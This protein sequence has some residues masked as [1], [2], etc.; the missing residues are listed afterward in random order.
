MS[1]LIRMGTSGNGVPVFTAPNSS[2]ELSRPFGATFDQSKS[3]WMYPAY[4]PVAGIVLE[5]MKALGPTLVFSDKVLAYR[6]TL[7]RIAEAYAAT[8]LPTGF[9]FITPPYAHQ[10]LGLA[11]VYYMLR[12]ALFYAPGLGKSKIAIDLL[13][14]LKFTGKL[15]RTLLLGPLVTIRNWGHEIDIHSGGELTWTAVLGTPEAKR[16]VIETSTADVLLVTYDTAS[17]YCDALLDKYDYRNIIADESHNIKSWSAS[18]TK[19]AAEL[20]Q[21]ADRRV[22]MT[23]TPTLGSP[24]DLYGQFRFLGT[25][26][27]PE[28]YFKYRERFFEFS[29]SNKYAILG[30]KNLPILNR[31]TL[32]ISVKKSKEECLDLPERTIQ[33]ISFDLSR[34]ESALYNK[35]ILEMGLDLSQLRTFLAPDSFG[36]KNLVKLGSTSYE[37]PS[38]AVLLNKLGQV[39]SGFLLTSNVNPTICDGCPHLATC[40]AAR[41]EPYTK[42]C[43]VVTKP[44]EP[45]LTAVAKPAAIEALSD[46]L[47]SILAEPT[48]KVLIWARYSYKGTELDAIQTLV[49]AKGVG[50]VRV[51]GRTGSKIQDL[52][53]KFNTDPAIRVY[54]AQI[55]TGVGITLNAASYMIY[56]SID[57]SLGTYLQSLD[58]NYRIGQKSAVTVYRLIGSGTVDGAILQLLDC[59]VEV[60]RILTTRIDNLPSTMHRGTVR[61]NVIEHND[62]A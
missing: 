44:P 24:D 31:R 55:A 60:D 2:T 22:I 46:L 20:S 52:V 25:Y 17:R 13:R 21:K 8:T 26:F 61:A 36:V 42:A 18:R 56:F 37:V 32:L 48:S 39:R 62:E 11:H 43:Q 28:P 33:D 4:F 3:L 40:V 38:I 58:R 12:A 19:S 30:Y 50:F 49:E 29:D 27:M 47:D 1:I 51:D 57:Y 14:L 59:K 15:E 10:L 23:G 16:Q 41:I 54:I 35:L 53:D 45:T 34:D 7:T 6:E 5:D 9:T